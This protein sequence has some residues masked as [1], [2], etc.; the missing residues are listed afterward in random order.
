MLGCR[1]RANQAATRAAPPP[2]EMLKKPAIDLTKGGAGF[3]LATKT[4]PTTAAEYEAALRRGYAERLLAPE[5]IR[6]VVA[7]DSPA[8]LGKIEIDIS[9]ASVRPDFTPQLPKDDVAPL[10][11]LR[12]GLL[13]Y[14]ADPLNYQHFSAGMRLEV[15]DP[16]LAVLPA[17]DGTFGLSL[18]DCSTGRAKM[19]ISMDGLR[20]SLARGVQV[21]QTMAFGIDSIEMDL[22]SDNPHALALDM[23]VHARLLLIP[24][25]FRMTGRIDV[26]AAFNVHFSQL[27]AAGLDP[28]GKVVAGVV[29]TRLDKINGKAAPLLKL[30][31]DKIRVSDLAIAVNEALTIDIGLVGSGPE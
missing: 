1:G 24:A 6:I 18:V 4:L 10:G 17:G 5:Q 8:G 13:R 16:R 14:T 7:P 31:G 20:E 27:N 11:Y 26:D 19:R 12:T 28:T 21:K 2:P 22:T 23:T 9:G 3:P 15:R 29:Q 25:S 30:P